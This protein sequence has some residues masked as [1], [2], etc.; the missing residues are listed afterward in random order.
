MK[1]S[2]NEVY[3]II[4]RVSCDLNSVSFDK[5]RFSK[6]KDYNANDKHIAT[7]PGSIKIRTKHLKT[8]HDFLESV[9]KK[10]LR[11]SRELDRGFIDALETMSCKDQSSHL[12]KK[13]EPRNETFTARLISVNNNFQ[14][15]DSDT[16]LFSLLSSQL[17]LHESLSCSHFQS[18]NHNRNHHT[19]RRPL[20]VMYEIDPTSN[21]FGIVRKFR[22]S[23]SSSVSHSSS[24]KPRKLRCS[25]EMSSN[26]AAKVF[27]DVRQEP[28]DGTSHRNNNHKRDEQT[29][30]RFTLRPINRSVKLTG[31]NLETT[32]S[33]DSISKTKAGNKCC[34]NTAVSTECNSRQSTSEVNHRSNESKLA[35]LKSRP[36]I[37]RRN[38]T[39]READD[40]FPSLSLPLPSIPKSSPPTFSNTSQSYSTGEE[41]K[42]D[43]LK[44]ESALKFIASQNHS[45][46]AITE[47]EP[48][49]ESY[50]QNRNE[51]DENT[52]SKDCKLENSVESKI[53]LCMEIIQ[54]KPSIKKFITSSSSSSA[55]VK[56]E[57]ENTVNEETTTTT[58]TTTVA[59]PVTVAVMDETNTCCPG[60]HSKSAETT[61]KLLKHR[62]SD[63]GKRPSLRIPRLGFSSGRQRKRSNPEYFSNSSTSTSADSSFPST[64]N[65]FDPELKTTSGKRLVKFV[66]LLKYPH[67]MV[68]VVHSNF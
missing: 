15:D 13:M 68:S 19:V 29:A 56:A 24:F 37:Q 40:S 28:D 46:E 5:S 42:D 35:F 41:D 55:S 21:A 32:S 64:S 22:R 51:G 57:E 6:T 31:S 45:S 62:F 52:D 30:K 54:E 26:L 44:S 11:A 2:W 17:S 39:L 23:F 3:D 18:R 12:N 7:F 49:A 67:L 34:F 60:N 9:R 66:D 4:D 27:S 10:Q 33:A 43:N 61:I 47:K 63:P 14:E 8:T 50:G 58:K 36:L 1:N 59:P 48:H 20:S 38:T 65:E 53:L 16:R 25:A